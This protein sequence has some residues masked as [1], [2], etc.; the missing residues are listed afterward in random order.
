MVS[1]NESAGLPSPMQPEP[2]HATAAI[3]DAGALRGQ[4]PAYDQLALHPAVLAASVVLAGADLA[5]FGVS[6]QSLVGLVL[7]PALAVLSAVDIRHRRL[8]NRIVL[9]AT[10]VVLVAQLA[11]APDHGAEAALAAF[12]AA[13]ALFVLRAAYP[14]GLGMGDVKLALLLGAALGY[15]VMFALFAGS[16]GAA[17]AGLVVIA[18][19]GATARKAVLPFGPFLA[20]GAALAFFLGVPPHL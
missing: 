6:R 2:A 14:Q 4:R 12:G 15:H 17:A 19:D 13:A 16:L 1:L 10:G 9:P 5:R 18:R 11:L 3:A 8:P 20:A 7:L